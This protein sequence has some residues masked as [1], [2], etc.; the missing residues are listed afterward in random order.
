MYGYLPY[1]GHGSYSAVQTQSAMITH[2]QFTFKTLEKNGVLVYSSLKV[3][4]ILVHNRC[5]HTYIYTYKTLFKHGK[6]SVLIIY[7]LY[8][9]NMT[10]KQNTYLS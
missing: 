3:N 2:L 7:K 10:M 6:S 9:K 1:K 4:I 8:I 5:V